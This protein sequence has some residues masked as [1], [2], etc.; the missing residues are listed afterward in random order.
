MPLKKI[1][2][3]IKKVPKMAKDVKDFLYTPARDE[4]ESSPSPN[5]WRPEG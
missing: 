1:W 4:D 2:K 3:G 5:P